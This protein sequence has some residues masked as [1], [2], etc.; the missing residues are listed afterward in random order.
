MSICPSGDQTVINSV[1]RSLLTCNLPHSVEVDNVFHL[2]QQALNL[3]KAQW[4]AEFF[5]LLGDANRLRILLFLAVKELCVCNIA[6]VID[7]SES[8]GSHQLRTLRAMRLVS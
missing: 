3:N 2:Q 7:M 6:A 8:V 4:M 5:S 1:K